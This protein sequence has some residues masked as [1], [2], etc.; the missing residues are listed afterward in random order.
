MS[1][2]LYKVYFHF[3]VFVLILTNLTKP[4]EMHNVYQ[5]KALLSDKTK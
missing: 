4:D 5:N 1:A 3:Q 2:S